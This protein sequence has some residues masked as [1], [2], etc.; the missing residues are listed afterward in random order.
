MPRIRIWSTRTLKMSKA[1]ASKLCRLAGLRL[2]HRRFHLGPWEL[3]M[4]LAQEPKAR[5]LRAVLAA[6]VAA[7]HV[8]LAARELAGAPSICAC[9]CRRA[10][11]GPHSANDLGKVL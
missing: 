4:L 7:V 5:S 9:T 2:L 10:V 11:R 8:E 1:W 3:P 6:R